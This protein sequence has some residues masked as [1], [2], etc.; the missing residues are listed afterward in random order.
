MNFFI[1]ANGLLITGKVIFYAKKLKKTV[2]LPT[3]FHRMY[4]ILITN[5]K[6][7]IQHFIS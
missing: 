4:F 5:Y 3:T 2:E 7:K 6:F 1:V